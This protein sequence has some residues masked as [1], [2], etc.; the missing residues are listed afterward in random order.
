MKERIKKRF[1]EL[2]LTMPAMMWLVIFFVIP[3]IVIFIIAFKEGDSFGG[4]GREW[5]I[6][7]FSELANPSYPVIMWR[8]IWLSV[9]TTVICLVLSVPS[10]YYLARAEKKWRDI[11]LLLIIVPFWS[12]FLIRIFAWKVVL[13]PEGLLKQV[14]VFFHLASENTFLLYRSEAVLLVLVYTY[15]PFALLPIYAAAEKFNFSLME[16]AYDLGAGRIQAFTRVYLPGIKQGLI[17]AIMVVLI[18]ALGSYVIPDIVG[19]P[20]G[21]M[22]GN[23]IAQRT[24]VDRNLPQASVIS[25]LLILIVMVPLMIRLAARG[26]KNGD[27]DTRGGFM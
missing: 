24:F 7:N 1:A 9:L 23:K 25:T 4:I 6:R 3:T 21:E 13:H 12:N 26:R 16:A 19:G 14:L 10:A 20:G 22:I 17:T 18:P 11:L 5:T 2:L 8:T 27:A 15:L